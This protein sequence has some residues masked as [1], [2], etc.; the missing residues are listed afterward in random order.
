PVKLDLDTPVLV[1]PEFLAGRAH[2]PGSLG[3]V[4]TRDRRD[5]RRAILNR[6]GQRRK[7][8][9]VDLFGTAVGGITAHA[10]A[11]VHR[12]D[13]VFA[14]F[15]LARVIAQREQIAGRQAAGIAC[16]QVLFLAALQFF[17]ANAG[18]LRAVLRFLEAALP[19]EYL[20]VAR[21]GTAG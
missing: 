3:A 19:L 15:G 6:R 21:L 20:Q 2:H 14:V 10:Y 11:V 5:A 9:F 17:K 18:I 7:R 13:Q 16:T 12:H 8:N 4:G 1:R